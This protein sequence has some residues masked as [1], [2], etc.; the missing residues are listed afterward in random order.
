MSL[1]GGKPAR[2]TVILSLF[3]LPSQTQNRKK[4]CQYKVDA[5]APSWIKLLQA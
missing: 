2:A 5:N 1:H 4:K 3:M